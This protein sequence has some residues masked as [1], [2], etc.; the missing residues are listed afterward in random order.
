MEK[1]VHKKQC[2]ILYIRESVRG[3]DCD[4]VDK[5]RSCVHRETP[6]PCWASLMTRRTHAAEGVS[7]IPLDYLLTTCMLVRISSVCVRLCMYVYVYTCI[8]ARV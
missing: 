2:A 3:A 8:Y 4:T 6:P 7:V 1:H 5:R